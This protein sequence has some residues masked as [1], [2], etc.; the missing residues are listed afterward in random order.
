MRL[1]V[2]A[3][4]SGGNCALVSAGGARILVDCGISLRR[5]RSFL[6]E[7]GMQPEGLDGVFITH[8]HTDHISGL[9]MLAKRCAVPIYALR[10]VAASLAGMLPET[11]ALL[12][13]LRPGE[14]APIAACELR[15]FE[16]QHDTSASAGVRVDCAA[17]A[18]G[19]CTDLGAVTDTVL[20]ALRGVSTAL[21]EANHDERMLL[22]GSYPAA[23][24]RRI[25][26]ERGH[27][28]NED[29][30]ALAVYL[31]E[32]GAETL[33]LG[34]ISRENNTPA[35]ALRA[36]SASLEAAGRSVELLAALPLGA[37]SAGSEERCPA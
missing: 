30:A 18:V 37:V 21:I 11:E 27:L 22:D 25:L 28:S 33:I 19:V 24:K 10:G 17:G 16:T 14:T 36:V 6:A 12:R 5:L 34:H 32:Y 1:T 20:D 8:T 3:S 23:L 26:S 31:A 13:P 4:G 7:E 15:C 35:L 9:A 29:C 2:F